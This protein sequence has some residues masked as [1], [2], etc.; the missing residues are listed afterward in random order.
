MWFFILIIA[1]V[2]W[3]FAF[4]ESVRAKMPTPWW[5]KAIGKTREDERLLTDI[6]L[7]VA[8]LVLG[9]ILTLIAILSFLKRT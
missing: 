9:L 4:N 6:A 3:Y 5:I 2:C 1:A 7:R 8:A